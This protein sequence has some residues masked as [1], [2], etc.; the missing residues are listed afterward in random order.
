MKF[1]HLIAY[2]ALGSYFAFAEETCWKQVATRGVGQI[3]TRCPSGMRLE[4]GLCYTECNDGYTAGITTCYQDCP[5]G[6]GNFISSC[7]KPSYNRSPCWKSSSCNRKIGWFYYR[8]CSSG[9]Y[10][11]GTMCYK[12]CPDGMTDIGLSCVPDSY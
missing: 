6:F 9:Y 2:M 10:E 3:P 1:C 12:S 8:S 4:N 11:S 5:S 7:M